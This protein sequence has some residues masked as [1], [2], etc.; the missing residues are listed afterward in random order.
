M[1][2]VKELHSYDTPLSAYPE[3][4]LTYLVKAMLGEEY[5]LASNELVRARQ[6]EDLA[7]H[8]E[9][10]TFFRNKSELKK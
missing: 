5:D 10:V 3:E 7:K 8:L 9:G 6:P 4:V 2:Y 1:E